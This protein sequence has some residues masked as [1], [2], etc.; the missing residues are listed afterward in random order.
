MIRA[1]LM[2]AAGLARVT[3]A[4]ESGL[5][6]DTDP[7]AI[8]SQV[9]AELTMALAK[10][11]KAK[12]FYEQLAPSYQLQFIG[13]IAVAKREETK[14]RRVEESITLLRLGKKLGMK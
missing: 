7:P 12:E 14:Q 10:N 8:S 13:W 6:E 9:P 11:K 5:W 3:E 4:K 1:K 2:R